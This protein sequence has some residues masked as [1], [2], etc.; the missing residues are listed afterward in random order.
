MDDDDD[1]YGTIYEDCTP[2]ALA[3]S[4]IFD[5]LKNKLP[6]VPLC[7]GAFQIGMIDIDQVLGSALRTIDPE[8][9]QQILDCIDP[10]KIDNLKDWL[11]VMLADLQCRPFA[12][13]YIQK[14][15]KA[16]L[17]RQCDNLRIR[18]GK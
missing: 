10:M 17:D 16:G 7:R 12:C 15:R 1:I 8:I 3:F 9:N 18:D 5:N 6:T 2:E 14:L 13:Q 4:A 11:S